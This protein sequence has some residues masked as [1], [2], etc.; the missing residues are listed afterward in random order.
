MACS[1]V[2]FRRSCAFSA[3]GVRDETRRGSRQCFR[4]LAQA[5]RARVCYVTGMDAIEQLKEDLR[6]GRIDANRLVE[7]M[8]TLQ[9]K[10]Q[11]AEQRIAELEKQFG[12]L[13]PPKVDEP[14]SMRAEEKRQEA[15]A[16]KRKTKRKGRRGRFTT[17]T[18]SRRRA[19]RS[20]FFPKASPRAMS[21]GRTCGRCGGWKTAERC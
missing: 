5:G 10:L 6:Q 21:T 2:E 7:L 12:A 3:L 9:R 14:F 11:A 15:A 13:P 16:R 8:V 18:R 1:A 19:N 20:L 17:P 4:K